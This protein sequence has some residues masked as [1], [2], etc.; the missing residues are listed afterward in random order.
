VARRVLLAE[1][2]IAIALEFEAALRDAG[3]DVVGPA[4]NAGQAAE[5]ASGQRFDAAVM[6]FG[7]AQHDPQ[8]VLWPLV[9][10]GTP[11]VLLT[12]Y[13]QPMVPSWL[14][15]AELCLKPCSAVD[16]IS[17]LN[18]VLSSAQAVADPKE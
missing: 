8:A 7:L 4:L 11:I 15:S 13:E 9:A 14:P 17:K 3:F 6:D 16:L 12:G 1:D 5:L 10:T 18:Q 2:E